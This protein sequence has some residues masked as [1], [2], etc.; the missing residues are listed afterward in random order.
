MALKLKL[1]PGERIFISGALVRNGPMAAELDVLNRV[2]LLREKDILLEADADTPC[3]RLYVVVQT[4]YLDPA[5]KLDGF[6]LFSQMA[7]EVLK[8]APSTAVYFEK[9][10]PMVSDGKYYTALRE[11]RQLIAYEEELISHAQRS[12]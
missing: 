12:E 6:Q 7:M 4:L 1:K 2:P 8:A 5:N 10:H 3:K 9:I 11:I